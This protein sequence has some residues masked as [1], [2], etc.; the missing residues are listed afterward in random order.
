MKYPA[1]FEPAEEGGFVV[2]FPDIKGAITQGDNEH[3]ALEMAEDALVTMIASCI[4]HGEPVPRPTQRKGW[5]YRMIEL[6]AMVA[7]KAELYIAFMESGIRK[8][9][10]SRRLGIPKTTVDRLFDFGNHTRLDQIEAAF[11]ALGKRLDI[12][13]QTAA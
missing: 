5:Q 11:R 4:R 2:T 8:T 12:T 7:V 10:L 13:V 9:E 3:D 1:L 6:P